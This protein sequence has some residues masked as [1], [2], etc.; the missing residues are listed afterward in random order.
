ML[1]RLKN[2][3]TLSQ[4]VEG[5]LKD[6]CTTHANDILVKVPE[7]QKLNTTIKAERLRLKDCPLRYA[8]VFI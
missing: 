2:T 1:D 3:R 5:K 6:I 7:I 8:T 4:D